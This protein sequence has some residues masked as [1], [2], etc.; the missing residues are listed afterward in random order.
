MRSTNRLPELCLVSDGKSACELFSA[1][2]VSAALC[3]IH[4]A[5]M[6]IGANPSFH[7]RTMLRAYRNFISGMLKEVQNYKNRWDEAS[8][9]LY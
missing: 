5:L 2:G 1:S 8:A 7:V 9:E 6:L 3:G 4:L